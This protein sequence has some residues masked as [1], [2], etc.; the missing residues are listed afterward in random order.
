MAATGI[1][2]H[3][4]VVQCSVGTGASTVK[5]YREW[6]ETLPIRCC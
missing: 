3:L 5:E 1:A 2:H 6:H 4:H